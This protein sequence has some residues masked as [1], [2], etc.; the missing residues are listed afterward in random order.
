M[1]KPSSSSRYLVLYIL[2]SIVVDEEHAGVVG[3]APVHYKA[4]ADDTHADDDIKPPRLVRGSLPLPAKLA[5]KWMR[6]KR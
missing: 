1:S 2:K 4:A 5:N 6:H 3:R